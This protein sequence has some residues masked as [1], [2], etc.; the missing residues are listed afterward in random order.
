MTAYERQ[1]ARVAQRKKKPT[2]ERA[3]H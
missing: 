3:S 1:R 2:R